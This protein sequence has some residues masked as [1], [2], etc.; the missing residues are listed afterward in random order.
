MRELQQYVAETADRL[1]LHATPA[2]LLLDLQARVGALADEVVRATE[3]GR[4]PFRPTQ[5]WE[6]LL[7]DVTFALITL[8]DQTGIDAD[9][10][11]RVAADRMYRSAMAQQRQQP[12]TEAWPFSG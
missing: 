10:A 7:G 2:T 3:H 11:V 1:G 5:D 4:R 9:R 12:A 6:A 8:A